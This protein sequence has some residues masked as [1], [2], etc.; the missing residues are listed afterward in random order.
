MALVC[1]SSLLILSLVEPLRAYS[2]ESPYRAQFQEISVGCEEVE[3]L[4]MKKLRFVARGGAHQAQQHRVSSTAYSMESLH[5]MMSA[6]QVES[7]E[8]LQ[9][10]LMKMNLE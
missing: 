2:D 3:E 10:F 7:A 9:A 1:D 4:Q 8:S 6:V 5:L